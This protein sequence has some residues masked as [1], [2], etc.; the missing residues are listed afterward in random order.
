MFLKGGKWL[1]QKNGDEDG[2]LTEVTL[3]L[4][5]LRSGK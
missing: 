5:M 4:G 2:R 1:K 3:W